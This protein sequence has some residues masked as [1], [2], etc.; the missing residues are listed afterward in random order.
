MNSLLNAQ[1]PKLN[2]PV[3]HINASPNR[4]I[5]KDFRHLSNATYRAPE[6]VIP[7]AWFLISWFP[8]NFFLKCLTGLVC[9]PRK[10]TSSF[11]YAIKNMPGCSGGAPPVPFE[12]TG[13]ERARGV[14][15]GNR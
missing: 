9:L 7:I 3:F 6:I 10:N 5:A 12:L 4:L 11:P 13:A 8:Y 15:N 1:P 14:G 2:V